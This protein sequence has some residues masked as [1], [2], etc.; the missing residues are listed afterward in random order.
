MP[1]DSLS[2][3]EA[4]ERQTLPDVV[5]YDASERVILRHPGPAV[6]FFS[7][8]MEQIREERGPLL[9]AVR[10]AVKADNCGRLVE[11]LKALM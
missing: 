4:L 7:E 10:G 8:A 3:L 2:R 11:V 6:K 5:L 1:R 9:P